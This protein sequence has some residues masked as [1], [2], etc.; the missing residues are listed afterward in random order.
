MECRLDER[1]GASGEGLPLWEEAEVCENLGR[2]PGRCD[3][4]NG[5]AIAG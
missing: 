3:D 1:A 4:G 2:G 5:K